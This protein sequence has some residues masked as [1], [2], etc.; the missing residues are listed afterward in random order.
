M[1]LKVATAYMT[2][3][4]TMTMLAG[5]AGGQAADPT[6]TAPRPTAPRPLVAAPVSDPAL[7]ADGSV[8]FDLLMPHAE[9]VALELEGKAKPIAMTADVTRPGHWTVTVPGLKPEYYSYAFQVDGQ[10]VIDPRNVTLKPSAF[11]VM[12]VFHIPGGMP[13]DDA[14]V[15]HG[16]IHHHEY[17]SGIVKRNSDYYVY[18]PPG[19]DAK[20]KYPVLYLLHGY[21]DEG[22]AWT[23]MG[24]ANTIFDNLLA[25]GKMK[26]MIVVM[27]LGY[28]DM[29]MIKRGW[30]AW[31][32]KDLVLRNF[33]NFDKALFTEVMPRV[34]AEYP[35]M[36]GRENHAIAGLS[37]GGAE[38]LF[39]GLN[40]PQDFAWVGGF[41]AGGLG[42]DFPP[43]FPNI[44]AATGAKFNSEMKLVWIACGTE[45][46]LLTPNQASGCMAA[47]GGREADCGGDAGHARVAGVA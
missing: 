3:L 24:K 42:T 12:N 10:E 11:R 41:S 7:N 1:T 43:V 26:P 29:D 2:A 38:S 19:Y 35:L 46:G 27:P 34:K 6:Q 25:V 30:A 47:G 8:T 16:V 33:T 32:D 28:G 18:T 17:A 31:Q 13:W 15:P 22:T 37:M 44:T 14:D 45:D 40:H 21:S 36:D 5:M 9:T 39:V 23:E 4:T 20:K